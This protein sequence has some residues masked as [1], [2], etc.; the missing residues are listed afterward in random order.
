MS[1]LLLTAIV[2]L[3]VMGPLR[4][5]APRWPRFAIDGLHRD[6]SL[7]VMA[8]LVL[9]IA[10]SV[11]DGFAPIAWLDAVIPLGSKYRPLWLGLGALSF[12]LLLAL[13]ITSLVRRRLGYRTWRAVHWAAYASWP[14]AVAHGLGTGSDAASAWM[15]FLT[16]VCVAAVVVAVAIRIGRSDEPN[17]RVPAIAVTIITP[18]AL[19][20]LAIAGP[21]AP[22]WARRAGTPVRLVAHRSTATAPARS[23]ATPKPPAPAS[24]EAAVLGHPERHDPSDA[25]AGRRDPRSRAPAQRRGTGR[26]ARAYGRGAGSNRR[27]VPDRE[28]GR[29]VRD[30]RVLGPAGEDRLAAGPGVHGSGAG[31][32]RSGREPPGRPPDRQPVGHGD[33]DAVGCSGRRRRVSID[34]HHGLPRLL[35]G[36]HPDGRPVSLREHERIHGP[37]PRPAGHELIE[38]IELSGLRGRGGAD[39]PTAR[40]LRAVAGTGDRFARRRRRASAVVVN[41]SETEPASAKDALLLS[42]LPHLVLDGAMLCAL[43]VGASE[44]IVKVGESASVVLESVQRALEE[45]GAEPVPIEVHGAP[46]GYVSGEESAVVHYLNGGASLP[47]FIPP[48]PF[49]RGYRGRPTLIQNPETLAQVALVARFGPD[50]Y[51]ELGTAAD[52]GSAL[53]TISGAVA[54]P[55]VYELAFGTPMVDLLDAAG[56]A[57]EP[58]QALLVGGYF[59][60]W[61]DAERALDVAAGAS[62]P[63]VDRRHPRLRRPHRAGRVI[64]RPAGERARDRVPGRRVRRPVRAVRA[65]SGCGGAV[66]ERDRGGNGQLRRARARAAL[67][68]GD[69]GSGRL[70]PP[71]RSGAAR[72]EHVRHVRRRDRA[73]PARA[74]RGPRGAAPGR[75]AASPGG[76]AGSPTMSRRLR[77]N[78]IACEAHGL[79]AELLPELIRL[80]DWGYPIIEEARVP[81]ELENLA[82]KAVDVCPTLALLLER[83]RD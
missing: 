66:G 39:F 58:L 59:G 64:V 31:R 13:V 62:G 67:V 29:P 11:L 69:P 20:I 10:T 46:E 82:R 81:G 19:V 61:V 41:G 6:L 22:N 40:K 65:R 33:G 7:L 52:P 83:A 54:A 50:W 5:A 56:G 38:A 36:L 28:P 14:V 79:C 37:L 45:R 70:P 74:L 42:R 78:P 9:H 53:V 3:G 23:A 55:G 18:L 71:G 60:T 15:L 49:E 16:A 63:A 76:G 43:A 21:L 72:G 48:R 51:R 4:V 30:R 57:V 47:T 32:R 12:D 80:D 34:G 44:V 27:L 73:P 8:V 26:A 24:L 25:G 75:S 2:V 68:L 17:V 1:L 77:V 35:A